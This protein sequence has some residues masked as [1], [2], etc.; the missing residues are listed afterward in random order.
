MKR[1]ITGLFAP[2]MVRTMFAGCAAR[3]RG[4]QTTAQPAAPAPE[5]AETMSAEKTTAAP[6]V[7]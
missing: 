2:C 1:M 7:L 6:K 3:Q 4:P 5:V